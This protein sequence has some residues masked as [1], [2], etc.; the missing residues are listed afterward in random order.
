MR[1]NDY[2][3][4]ALIGLGAVGFV[5]MTVAFVLIA[6]QGNFKSLQEA[7]AAGRWSLPRRLMFAGALLGMILGVGI[8]VLS[9]LPGGLWGD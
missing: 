5:L 1:W 8:A 7:D 9:L 4:L 3:V 6:R 2:A